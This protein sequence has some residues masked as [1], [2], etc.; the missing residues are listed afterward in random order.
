MNHLQKLTLFVTFCKRSIQFLLK[1][2]STSGTG[3]GRFIDMKQTLAQSNPY[4]KNAELRDAAVKRSVT[5]SS[6]IEG[7]I[8]S[9]PQTKP[10]STV[11]AVK[12]RKVPGSG[13]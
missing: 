3:Y 13:Q 8:V 5:S 4:L 6:A 1:K 11:A 12:V 9:L 2:R 7:I 10:S